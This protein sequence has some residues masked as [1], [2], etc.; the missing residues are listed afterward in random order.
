MPALH[1]YQCT[2][3]YYLL[4]P[5]L[6]Y[7]YISV[8]GCIICFNHACVT[9]VSVYT[10]VLFASTM[11]A[12]HLYQCTRLYCLLQPCLRYICISVHGCIICFNHACV[13]FVSVYTVVLFA[14]TM[15]ALHLYQ[16]TRLYCLLQPCLRYI[17]ISVHGCIIC[18]N[19]ACVTFV[20]VY[21]V[22]LFASTMPA[23]HLYQCTRLYYLLQPCLRYIYISVHG[24]IICFN[25]ACVTFVSVYTVVLFASTMPALYL[26]QCTRLYYL[27][28]PCLR[29][30]CISVHGCIVC[31]NHACV[32]FVSVYTVVLFA[33][34]MPAVHLYQ[35]TRLYCLLQPCLRYICISVHGCIICFN[36]ACVTFVSVYT[37]VLF[38]STMPALHLY[39]CTRLYYLLQ[40]CLRYICI[41][42]HGC[43]I[44]FNHACVTFV[45]VYTVVLFASTMPA[46]HLYQCT[47]L[48]YLLQPCLRYIYISVH[49]CIICFNHA[50][51]TFVSVYTVVLFASTMP[52]L[53]LYQCTR[54][55]C[56]LHPCLRYICISVHGCIVC[57]NHACGTFVSVYTVVL[58]ASTMPALHLYQCTRLYYLLQPCLRYICISVH[59]CIICFNHACVTFVS[60]YTVVLFASTMP[61]LHLY[62]CTRLY[63]LLQPY[64]R[65]IY[66]SVHGCIICFNHACVTFVSVY[67]VVLFASTMPALHLYQCTLL[68]C[69]LHPCLRY[70]CISVHGCIVCFNHA[71]VTFV[72]VYTV[73]LFASTMPALHLY[74][75]TRLYYLLQP[76][77]RYICIS[78]HGCIICFNHACVTF[79]S[80]YTVVLFASTMPALHLYQCTRL[81]YLLQPCLRYICISAHGCII[82]FNHACVTFVSV[83]TVVLFASTMPALHLYQCT[84]LYYLLQPCLRYICI[85]AHGCI[86]CFNHACVT[87]VSVHTVVLFAS[88]M[89]ALH[90]YQCT[91]LYYLLQP[92]LRYICISAHGCI[93]C[94][95]HA[96]V[97]FVSV[98]TVVLFASTMPA[99]HLYQCTR[100]YY[101]LQPCLRYICISA[102]GCIICF[103]H[104]CVTFVSVYT[105]VLFASTMP[106]LHLYQCTRLYYLLQPCLR[107]ICISVHGCIICF[108]HACVTFVSV[109][110]VVLFASTMPAL[111][112][113]QCTRLYYLLQPCLRYICISVHGCIICFNH[114]CVTFVSVYTVV[115]FA[116][117]MPALHLYQCTRLYYLIQ[118]CLRY[119]C[120]SVHGCII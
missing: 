117:T 58:F 30:I 80:V 73:V 32:T 113:Y 95:N 56:L 119:I 44:C 28:Q 67:T 49:G 3:L 87:F 61:A 51:V 54:L 62:Q 72:S 9:F 65:Y 104:A 75:C 33:S 20:S 29:Y 64:L 18:F 4:Q 71:C 21:T 105:V 36:H 38:A 108:N 98:H 94:F 7:I 81:Y 17:C 34:S 77:L 88:T 66:I 83:H 43:I 74:Q 101:L 114:A 13:T 27:L 103:N 53:H 112:L 40:P 63:Y 120:I 25:H 91:R 78:V 31:F 11:P 89:P 35:C 85:S 12:L 8:H 55:Y 1:L 2:R 116:S 6:R 10:V 48:Y 19:H 109:Y 16:C 22:V 26:Y 96:C 14:S 79:V 93:I 70:I 24:C 115:L 118:P 92:C 100:L 69:L 5:Y 59:G 110:T 39:Q 23:L 47:R 84:R 37:V 99:L 57:F 97:T 111:H 45:S 41:S 42:V 102:H 107:Y 106:A 60:V 86:I 15:P 52:A 76:C 46:L 90:L 82:C 68:Y 50:C